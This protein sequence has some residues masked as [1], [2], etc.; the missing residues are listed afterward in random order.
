MKIVTLTTDWGIRDYYLAS[1]KAQLLS[2]NHAV[3]IVD[4]SHAV[5]PFD[6]LQASFTLKN[7]YDKFPEGTI[8][9]IGVR[10]NETREKSQGYLLVKSNNHYFIGYDS[11]IFSLIL[12]DDEKEIFLLDV[13]TLDAPSTIL[14]HLIEIISSITKEKDVAS[15]SKPVDHFMR[16]LNPVVTSNENTIRG[17]ILYIDTFQNAITNIPKELFHHIS[18][19]RSFIVSIKSHQCKFKK[20]TTDYSNSII[21]EPV[22]LF[23]EK[24]FLE[25]ALHRARA[26][27]LLGIKIL[28]PIIVE[29]PETANLPPS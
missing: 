16:I 6:I 20:L 2:L 4:V 24:G 28:D 9:F 12:V 17:S 10:G 14:K 29:F 22:I 18:Q 3:Q 26:A 7:C 11:G 13:N 27:S 23:N 21:G 19:N 1:F 5:D 15:F 25:F 8:H